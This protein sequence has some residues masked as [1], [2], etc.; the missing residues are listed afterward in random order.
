MRISD[1]SSDVCS[2]DLRDPRPMDNV[3]F[4]EDAAFQGGG[5]GIFGDLLGSFTS[6]RIDSLA[7][8]A[9]G[10]FY[11]LVKDVKGA[12]TRAVP[13]TRKDRSERPRN[14]A[15]A[16]IVALGRPTEGER[17]EHERKYMGGGI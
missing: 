1:W 17:V 7:G 2:S 8:F 11:G 10:P 13:R 16:G 12:A 9:L 6:S 3:E 14:P 4:W 5:L 15:A